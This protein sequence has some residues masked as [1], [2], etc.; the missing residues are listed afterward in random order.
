MN[1]TNLND[2][3]GIFM[4]DKFWDK[5]PMKAAAGQTN[6]SVGGGESTDYSV[7][8]NYYISNNVMFRLNYTMMDIDNVYYRMDDKVSYSKARI[9]VNF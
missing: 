4:Q 7:A 2:I 3:D 5:D 8:L 9:Q 1:N 6:F